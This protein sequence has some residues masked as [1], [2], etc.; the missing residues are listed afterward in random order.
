M[1]ASEMNLRMT[2]RKVQSVKLLKQTVNYN[3]MKLYQIKWGIRPALV[4]LFLLQQNE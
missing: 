2:V 1:S 4:H 3:Y